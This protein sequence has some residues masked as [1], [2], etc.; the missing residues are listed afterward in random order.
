MAMPER[1]TNMAINKK[2]TSS[3]VASLASVQLKKPSTPA[4]Q[5]K[6]AGSALSQARKK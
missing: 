5:K 2:Q 4:V 3:K 1:N 6:V